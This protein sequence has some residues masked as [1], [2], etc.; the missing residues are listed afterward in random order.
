MPDKYSVQASDNYRLAKSKPM[1]APADGTYNLI[2]LPKF[3][4]IKNVWVRKDSAY[5]S[6]SAS[7]TVGFI[8]NGETADPDAFL[9]NTEADPDATGMATMRGGTGAEANGKWFDTARGALTVTVDDSSAA[10]G[11]FQV[12]CE[13]TVLK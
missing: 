12:F 13:Y 1:I 2:H 3:A 8:G 5:A 9:T 4:F 6:A 11:N 10:A 7:M